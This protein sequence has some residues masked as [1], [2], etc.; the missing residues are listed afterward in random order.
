MIIESVLHIANFFDGTKFFAKLTD[1]VKEGFLLL[2]LQL[3]VLHAMTI[4]LS[5][6]W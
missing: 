4:R 2:F 3:Y 6:A 1:V 5:V